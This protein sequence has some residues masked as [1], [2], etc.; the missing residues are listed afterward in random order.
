MIDWSL[1]LT[2][3]YFSKA[4][5]KYMCVYQQCFIYST[6]SFLSKLRA[7]KVEKLHNS[8]F[9]RN[10]RKLNIGFRNRERLFPVLWSGDRKHTYLFFWPKMYALVFNATFNNISVTLWLSS[11]IGGGNQSTLRVPQIYRKSH[12]IVLHY[13]QV[14]SIWHL[15]EWTSWSKS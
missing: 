2:L 15:P 8:S 5:K 9:Y 6:A 12:C 10:F 1:T 14:K 3:K 4:K 13:G 7:K 11:F